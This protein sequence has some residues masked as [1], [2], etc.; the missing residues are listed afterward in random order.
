MAAA[1]GRPHPGEGYPM[2]Q[3]AGSIG[4]LLAIMI[5]MTTQANAQKLQFEADNWVAECGAAADSDCSIIGVFKSANAGP[6]GSFSLLV[7]L[8][9]RMVA[10]VGKPSPSRATIRIDKNPAL[11]CRGDQYC[12]FSATD[13]EAIARQLKL[14]SLVL[15]DVVVGR[16]LFRAS[17]STKG[18]QADLGK[19]RAQG[20][21]IALE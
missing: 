1:A 16:D 3:N 20:F 14:G 12:I 7:D 5:C 15:I 21:P 10:I 9:N 17:I 8:R 6:T 11:E 19:I 13:A 18:Y 2:S 4:A